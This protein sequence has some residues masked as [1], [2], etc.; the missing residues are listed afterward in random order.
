MLPYLDP[1]FVVLIFLFLPAVIVVLSLYHV[2]V[3]RGKPV[4]LHF[5]LTVSPTVA[6]RS[7][8]IASSTI[9]PV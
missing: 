2:N 6:D 5:S 3:G 7:F 9:K 4:I 8:S 1:H